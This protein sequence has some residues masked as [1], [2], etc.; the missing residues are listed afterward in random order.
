MYEVNNMDDKKV[1]KIILDAMMISEKN[2]VEEY[3]TM[4]FKLFTEEGLP[5]EITMDKIKE[6]V[7][8]TLNEKILILNKYQNLMM[9]HSLKA[10]LTKKRQEKMQ[11]DNKL[12]ILQL[13]NTGEF[14]N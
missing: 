2:R 5:F 4:I 3:G 6:K 11:E 1:L 10:G 9:T 7:S 8:F 14:N 13:F 12:N